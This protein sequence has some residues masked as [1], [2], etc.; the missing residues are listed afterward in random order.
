VLRDSFPLCVK[1]TRPNGAISYSSA[2]N[3]DGI[4][5]ANGM[6]TEQMSS[7]RVRLARTEDSV[8]HVAPGRSESWAGW[9]GRPIPK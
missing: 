2:Q 7:H 9:P 5:V 1:L 6:P 4:V 8:E 3:R